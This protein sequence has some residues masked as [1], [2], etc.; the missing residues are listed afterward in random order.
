MKGRERKRFPIKSVL[1]LLAAALLLGSAVGSTRA[2]LT[3]YSEN[4]S[5]QVRMSSIGV[6]LLENGETVSSRA[7]IDDGVWNE[8][9][10]G[11]LLAH[12]PD[13]KTTGQLIPGKAYEERLQV[14]NTGTIDTF[15][16]VIITRYWKDAEGRKATDLSPALIQL[17]LAEESGWIY[18]D[19]SDEPDYSPEHMVFYYSKALAPN[20]VSEALSDTLRIDPAIAREVKI[21]EITDN[22]T[23]RQ[24]Y[25]YRYDGYSL[26][27]E[28][29]VNAVQTHSGAEAIKSAWGVDV[30]LSEDGNAITGIR[31]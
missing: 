3:Y 9:G 20:T 23:T 31:H 17:G 29:E 5:A 6:A 8:T 24:V 11:A 26:C 4:Y 2:A 14:K 18:D 15:V 12:M 30:I 16:R 19:A 1:V 13:G 27:L 21:S 25:E 10:K 28:A 7:Y 22:G